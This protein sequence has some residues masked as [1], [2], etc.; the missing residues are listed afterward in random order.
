[1]FANSFYVL[2]MNG[3]CSVLEWSV[4]ME[5]DVVLYMTSAGKVQIMVGKN[6][7]HCLQLGGDPFLPFR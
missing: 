4:V 3:S 1:M 5:I 6:I 2:G 7:R